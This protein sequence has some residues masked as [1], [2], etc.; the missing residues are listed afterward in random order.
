MKR[1]SCFGCQS[2]R[3]VLRDSRPER[4]ESWYKMRTDH[5]LVAPSVVVLRPAAGPV[6]RRH[7]HTVVP[8]VFAG[9]LPAGLG[10]QSS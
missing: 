6:R 10:T 2:V 1:W 8:I 7:S 5:V 3:E 4:E 9:A